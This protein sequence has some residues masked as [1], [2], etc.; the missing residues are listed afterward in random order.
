MAVIRNPELNWDGQTRYR[1]NRPIEKPSDWSLQVANIDGEPAPY[2]L[3]KPVGFEFSSSF[4]RSQITLSQS[5]ILPP[6]VSYLI[7]N[8]TSHV[9]W[10]S[11]DFTVAWRIELRTR[12]RTVETDNIWVGRVKGDQSYAVQINNGPSSQ[13]ATLNI[14]YYTKWADS[15]GGMY[16]R[17]IDIQP[18]A[19]AL[20]VRD[21]IP[22]S[23]T[24]PP[25]QPETPDVPETENPTPQDPVTPPSLLTPA[26]FDAVSS[27]MNAA[28][29]V[30]ETSTDPAEVAQALRRVSQAFL[31]VARDLE[32]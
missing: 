31:N 5:V 8:N 13:P 20:P 28:A 29:T 14:V 23:S 27:E 12:R 10:G 1:D 4:I 7:V 18:N 24:P 6:G 26:L 17:R 9:T 3:H 32:A 25:Q 30:L 22:L 15:N 16:I 19:G 11:D 21:V 2:V